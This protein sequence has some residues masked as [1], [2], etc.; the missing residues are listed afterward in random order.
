MY[1]YNCTLYLMLVI[2]DVLT[3]VELV[4]VMFGSS[5]ANPHTFTV[6]TLTLTHCQ[7]QNIPSL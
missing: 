1:A 7:Q 4:T 5:L 6:F 2:V 3:S